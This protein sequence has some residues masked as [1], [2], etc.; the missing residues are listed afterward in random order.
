MSTAEL[1]I[2]AWV[3]EHSTVDGLEAWWRLHEECSETQEQPEI[4]PEPESEPRLVA[5]AQT[6]GL[7]EDFW[8][9]WFG[10]WR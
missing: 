1:E 10:F 3:Q 2:N 8:Q 6:P 7:P 9:D 5:R 4:Q